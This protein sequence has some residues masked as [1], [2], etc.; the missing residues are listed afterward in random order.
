MAFGGKI[1]GWFDRQMSR[2]AFL[3]AGDEDE[4]AGAGYQRY[5]QQH[6][7]RQHYEQRLST[8][9]NQQQTPQQNQDAVVEMASQ[10]NFDENH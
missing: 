10:A 4:A 3:S 2:L 8:Q 1:G 5:Q 7:L 9:Q 6:Q